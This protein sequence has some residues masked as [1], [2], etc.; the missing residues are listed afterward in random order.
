MGASGDAPASSVD[1]CAHAQAESAWLVGAAVRAR[2]CSRSIVAARAAAR[3][4]AVR[5]A[6]AATIWPRS[7]PWHGRAP[8]ADRARALRARAARAAA[9]PSAPLLLAAD[10]ACALRPPLAA[11]RSR[12]LALAAR[13]VVALICSRSALRLRHR[14]SRAS[15]SRRWTCFFTLA[16]LVVAA[17]IA[18]RGSPRIR[19]SALPNS[20]ERL[21]A[22]QR[23]TRRMRQRRRHRDRGSPC[24]G[25]RAWMLTAINTEGSIG[26]GEPG[27]AD[28][29]RRSGSTRRTR[30]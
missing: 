16:T 28:Q 7:L 4:R 15:R 22:A 3:A 17:A 20:V 5:A 19:C 8:G 1:A 9:W 6:G 18:R 23:A 29:R 21:R 11:Q 10:G 14:A 26:E 13:L 2:R 12:Q 30:C 25:W 27:R 24:A